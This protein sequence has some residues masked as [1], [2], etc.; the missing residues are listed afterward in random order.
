D[1][2]SSIE[3]PKVPYDE[4]PEDPSNN[5][6]LPHVPG[7][8][9]KDPND[10]TGKTPLKPVDPNDPTKGYI[11]PTITDPNDPTKDT[12]VPYTPVGSVVV[13]YKD[14][15]G[16]VIK[17]QVT[18]TPTSDVDTPYDTTDNKPTEITYKGD[19]Y[20]LVPSKTEGEESGKV[21]KGETVITYV[22]QKVG[23]WIP[24]IPGIPGKDRPKLPYP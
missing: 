13:R 2:D 24:E 3:I 18:D 11:P 7:Y 8:E 23:N 17:E 1:P 20:V 19:K 21:V 4:T 16:N 15:D 22:Y 14:T 6:P 9:P 10:P 5:P 12:P